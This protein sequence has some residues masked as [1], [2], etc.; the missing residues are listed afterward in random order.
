MFEFVHWNTFGVLLLA[1]L[2]GAISVIPLNRSVLDDDTSSQKNSATSSTASLLE[3]IEQVLTYAVIISVALI[4][5]F[6]AIERLGIMGAPIVEMWVAGDVQQ[7]Q[8]STFL[9]PVLAGLV[10]GTLLSPLSLFQ[11][12][13]MRVDFYKITLWKCLIA[14][15]FHGGIFEE[16]LF[17]W[18]ILSLLAWLITVTLGSAGSPTPDGVFWVANLMSALLFG[19]AHLPGSATAAPLT[20]IMAILVV[21]LNVL[22]GLVC[23]YFFWTKGIEAAIV[24]HMFFHIGLQPSSAILRCLFNGKSRKG[25]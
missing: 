13:D 19:V 6:F 25:Q 3:G 22:V 14:G 12:K 10:I 9:A 20:P 23:G 15:I 24:A 1:G 16:L 2:L 21:S 4:C 5:G 7:T 18:G 11:S 8:F 17:R